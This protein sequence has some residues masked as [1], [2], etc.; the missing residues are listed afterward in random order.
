MALRTIRTKED[1]ILRK[2][3]KEVKKITPR[4]LELIDDMLETMYDAE[5]VGLA[6]V[7]VGVLRRVVVI[8]IGEGPVVLINPEI[9]D[10]SEK[11]Y[12]EIEGCLSVPGE[13]GF[14][15]RPEEV[16]VKALDRDGKEQIIESKERFFSKAI[17]HELEHLDGILY[18]D[19]LVEPSE[20][21]MKEIIRQRKIEQEDEE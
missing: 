9:I 13:Q 6:A 20:E 15:F 8:D 5:G 16:T 4:T 11:E 10:K 3:S 12:L 21:Q 2:K 14:V 1:E 7:Q 19:H 18:T 17:C